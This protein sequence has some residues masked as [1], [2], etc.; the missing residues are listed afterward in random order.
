MQVQYDQPVWNQKMVYYTAKKLD[1]TAITDEIF[2][3]YALFKDLANTT[4][5]YPGGTSAQTKDGLGVTATQCE[6]SASGDNRPY[7]AGI[8]TNAQRGF[9]GPGWV[10]VINCGDAVDAYVGNTTTIDPVSYLGG[11][12]GQWY[13]TTVTGG[14]SSAAEMLLTVARVCARPLSAETIASGGAAKNVK[15]DVGPVGGVG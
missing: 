6:D 2:P 7:F 14:V 4:I 3:G 5:P 10:W 13:L 15:C 8:V 1:G 12:S 9:K 11:T